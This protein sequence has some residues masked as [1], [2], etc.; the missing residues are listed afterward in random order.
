MAASVL[1]LC[2]T[3][4]LLRGISR[5]PADQPFFDDSMIAVVTDRELSAEDIVE[6]HVDVSMSDEAFQVLEALNKSFMERHADIQVIMKNHPSDT[7]YEHLK[8]A[9]RLGDAADIMLLDNEKVLQYAVLARLQPMDD[10]YTSESEA[11]YIPTLTEQLRWNGYTW[12]IPYQVQPYIVAYNKSVWFE[13]TGEDRPAGI[14][15]LMQAYQTGQLIFHPQDVKVYAVLASAM[16]ADWQFAEQ[17]GSNSGEDLEASYDERSRI[18]MT[19]TE[20]GAEDA[21]AKHLDFDETIDSVL[22]GIPLSSMN[23]G[24]ETVSLAVLKGILLDEDGMERKIDEMAEDVKVVE[25]EG[26]HAAGEFQEAEEAQA[27]PGAGVSFAAKS[28]D[29]IWEKL[30]S[31]EAA[32]AVLPLHVYSS[33]ANEEVSAIL[34]PSSRGDYVFISGQSFVLAADAVDREAAYRWI[35]EIIEGFELWFPERNAGGYPASLDAYRELTR[36]QRAQLE[37]LMRAVEEGKALAPDPRIDDKLS[38]VQEVLTSK[39]AYLLS[40]DELAALI[41]QR[42]ADFGWIRN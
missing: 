14:E 25:S 21:E 39:Q 40:I 13:L 12:G 3:A 30:T 8:R 34:L 1:L 5:M 37:L 36:Q 11:E 38:I 9:F 23:H 22:Q 28:A 10:Y 33:Y 2:A 32:A 35:R 7:L 4:V 15:Q 41:E 26:E 42:F 18:D 6:L 16:D 19:E 17:T 20:S 24:E 31:G 29:E 27:V